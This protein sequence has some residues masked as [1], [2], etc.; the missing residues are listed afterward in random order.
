MTLPQKF[1]A[2]NIDKYNGET[3]PKIWVVNY[4]L[5]LK[6]ASAS[7]PNFMIQYLSIYLIDLAKT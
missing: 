5:A 6:A 3:D 1:C 7:D 4:C 2:P